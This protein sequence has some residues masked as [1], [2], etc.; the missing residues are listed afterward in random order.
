[1]THRGV[2]GVLLGALVLAWSAGPASAAGSSAEAV[3][4]SGRVTLI[5]AGQAETELKQGDRVAAGDVLVVAE[6]AVLDLAFD[7]EWEN[8][9]RVTGY[10]RITARSVDPVRLEMEQGDIFSRLRALPP[11]SS[12]EVQTPLA[13]A[14]A[15]GTEYR[16]VHG[17]G[18]T[19]VTN[20]SPDGSLVYVYKLDE[21]GNPTGDPIVLKPGESTTVEGDAEVFEAPLEELEDDRNRE[22][23]N[24][25]QKNMLPPPLDDRGD[26][27]DG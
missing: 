12:F 21:N 19:T 4:V 1:M 3:Q 13:I 25:L 15:R 10:A 18:A 11:G 27:Q 20:D 16:V 6:G 22:D 2:A 7:P 23:E 26:Q 14:T 17:D 8:A 5:R 9:S 24:Q